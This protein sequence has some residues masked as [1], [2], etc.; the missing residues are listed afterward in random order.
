MTQFAAQ[1][2]RGCGPEQQKGDRSP[3][4]DARGGGAPEQPAAPAGIVDLFAGIGCVARG[5]S[6][7]KRFQTL[8][9]YDVDPAARDTCLHNDPDAPYQLADVSGLT[10]D[11]IRKLADGRA[12]T[13]IVGCPPCQ[14]FSAAGR[15]RADDQRNKLLASFFAVVAAVKPLFFVMENV[16]SIIARPELS[17]LL[18]SLAKD[19]ATADGILNAACYGLP[20][21]RQRAIV[22]GYRRELEVT[23]TVP[24]PTHFGRRAVFLYPDQTIARPSTAKLDAILGES[25]QIGVPRSRRKG[26]DALLPANPETLHDLITVGDALADLPS[27]SGGDASATSEASA[28]AAELRGDVDEPPNH[29]PWRHTPKLAERLV[30]IPEGGRLQTEKRYYSQAYA[31]LHRDGLARTITTN[32][33]NAGC[34]RFTHYAEP[35]TL[36]IREAARLQGIPDS[37]EFI[38]HRSVQ[39][40]LI[41]NAFPELWAQAI[42]EHVG[43]QLGD[44][45]VSAESA[46]YNP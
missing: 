46:C 14:G 20:Q 19:Y 33:H 11:S 24:A 3:R 44:A 21:T 5:F 2:R 22:I 16:P 35:R 7:T 10:L 23:P 17:T 41:G 4:G 28:Y 37:F 30:S 18:R 27:L 1:A 40:R 8:A 38:H 6:R 43:T 29:E 25:P 12:V 34:G 42:A 45:L 13:G 26:M 36:T 15:R 9:L 31:R 39:E 32:F